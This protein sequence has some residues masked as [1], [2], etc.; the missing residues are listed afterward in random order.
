MDIT[1]LGHSSFKLRGKQTSLVTDPYDSDAVGLKFPKTDADIVTLSHEHSDHNKHALV[2]G[3][4]KIVSGPGEYEIAGVS[5]IGI[6][7]FHDAVK[8][9]ERGKNTIYVIEMDGF[10]I[11]H[12]GDLG[13]QLS[14]GQVEEIGDVHILLIPVGGVY[15]IDSKVAANIASDIEPKIII[16]MHYQV[17]GLKSEVF[18]GLESYEPFV[19]ALGLAHEVVPKLSLRDPEFLSEEQKIIILEKRN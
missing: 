3:V 5:V 4:K 19:K 9:K 15:T 7:S 10:R 13:H 18:S 2:E 6:P 16:P 11:C 17:E 14:E 8:G 12:L 1:Y